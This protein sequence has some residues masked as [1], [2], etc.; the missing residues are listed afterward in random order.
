[1]VE[2]WAL[3]NGLVLA[4]EM[5]L[6]NLVIELDPLSVVIFMNNGSENLLIEPLLTNCRNL[7]EEIPNKHMIHTYREANQ[8][9]DALAKEA[10]SLANFVV[11]CNPPPVVEPILAWDKTNMC[12]NRLVNS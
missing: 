11:F 2:L 10:Q 7:L 9:V 12:C 3:R 6:N 4:K 1:M 5:G 8:C